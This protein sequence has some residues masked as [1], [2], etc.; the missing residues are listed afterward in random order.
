MFKRSALFLVCCFMTFSLP[1]PALSGQTPSRSL[2]FTLTTA[3]AQGTIRTVMP[4]AGRGRPR[5]GIAFAGGGAKAAASIGVLKVL[6]KEGIPVDAIAGTSMGAIVGGFA[7][8]GYQPDEIEAIFLEND[9]N[10]LFSDTPSRAFLTQEQKEAGSRHLL[11]FSLIGASFLP[12]SG[13]TAGQKL[14]NLL[15]SKT[16]AS[17]FQAGLDFDRLSI[18]FRAVATDIETGATVVIGRGILS[19]AMRASSAIPVV[20]QPV[21][22]EGRLLVDGGM[23]NNL[24]VDVVRAM[25]VDLVIAVDPSSRLETR[26]RL[27]SLVDIMSQSISIPVR[28]D[29][30]RQA[31]LAD[32]VITPDTAAY[33]F[34]A[35]ENIAGIIRTGEEAARAALPRIREVLARRSALQPEIRYAITDLTLSGIPEAMQTQVRTTFDAAL[36]PAGA[37]EGELRELLA[38][39]YRL[40]VFKDLSLELVPRGAAYGAVITATRH[41]VVGA[42][43]I[44]GAELVPAGEIMDELEGQLG[45]PL[46]VTK[47]D[48]ALQRVVERYRKQGYLLVGVKHAGMEQ[49]GATLSIILSEGRVDGIRLA[50]QR[51]TQPSLIRRETR[52]EEGAPL[53]FTTLE[54]DIQRLYGLNFFDSL[55][56]DIADSG[57][58]GVILTFRIKEKPR[59][60]LLLGIR[61]DL[62]DSF[63]GLADLSVDNLAGRGIKLFLNTRF[64]NYT[65]LALGYR[66]PV[67]IDTYFVHTLQAFYS[68]RTYTLYTDQRRTGELDVTR[69]GV[70]FAFGYQWF[71]F[72]DTYL[73]YRY[74]SDH[75]VNIFGASGVESTSHVGSLAFLSTIDTRDRSA[76]PHTGLLFKGSYETAAHT[77]GGNRDFR[78]TALT[79]EGCLPL[80]ERH[81]VIINAAAGFGS[82]DLP[83]HEQFGIGGADSLLGFPLP[84]YY[85]REFVGVNAL[86][87]SV[88]YRWMLAEYQLKAVKALYLVLSG[89]AANVWDNRDD[90][91]PRDLRKGA[92]IGLHADTLIGPVRLDLGAGEDKRYMVYFSAGFDF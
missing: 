35:F 15:R 78:K 88:A 22:H 12:T 3:V 42:I 53:N 70:D 49:D 79:G 74:E 90:L 26:E 77:Y 64:G 46:N 68:D 6:Y 34:A 14:T 76:F 54:E 48:K 81:T 13:L 92:G 24:P 17:S 33:P 65:D 2:R 36:R 83:Y 55:N 67:L 73:R 71:R 60:T 27:S 23:S 28:R 38:A 25:G 61:Y 45:Q 30:E 87:A 16:L 20:F 19:D 86:G 59:G 44:S 40:G 31:E 69:T 5:I 84:G 51:R 85:R 37:T 62:E 43:R 9:L 91:S 66:S 72:G 1:H 63:T 47:V 29:T 39:I 18:P 8:A 52:L 57:G 80:A 82:G 7:A 75:A 58:D 10:D 21:E 89:G 4:A 32:V 56:V 50:G 41:P 11:Q